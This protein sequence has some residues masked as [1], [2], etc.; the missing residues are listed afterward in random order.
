MPR[1]KLRNFDNSLEF[2]GSNNGLTI[3]GY[4]VPDSFSFAFWIKFD[5][6]DNSD[7]ILDNQDG[8]PSGGFDLDFATA[9][10]KLS[11]FVRN[12]GSTTA[13]AIS[14]TIRK[15]VWYHIVGVRSTTFTQLYVNAVAEGTADTSSIMSATSQTLTI[16]KRCTGASNFFDG[17]MNQFLFFERVLTEDEINALYFDGII[18]ATPAIRYDFGDNIS[19][20]SGNGND[21]VAVGTLDY[22]LD[23]PNKTR[24]A[25][26][27]S[28]V[29]QVGGVDFKMRGWN[30][31]SNY[32]DGSSTN[33]WYQETGQLSYDATDISSAGMNVVKIYGTEANGSSHIAAINAMLAVDANLKF[34]VLDFVTYETDYSVA[35]GGA[36]RTAKI[37]DFVA[38]VNIFKDSD[39]VIGYGFGNENNVNLGSTTESDWY[40]LLDAACAAGKAVDSTRFY[41]TADADLGTYPGDHNVPNLDVLGLNI[42]RGATLT[43]LIPDIQRATR[44][45]VIIT[46]FG[47]SRTT[48]DAPDLATQSSEN[49]A[50]LQEI[51]SAYPT[52]SGWC[53]FKFTDTV[54]PGT[55]YGATAPLADNATEARTKYDT[56]TDFSTYLNANPYG[57]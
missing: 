45:P 5:T 35:T 15:G 13:Q 18:P 2:N 39:A 3:D 8:G 21:G 27:Y 16:G 52:I 41:F 51:E 50:L 14:S 36:N 43:D 31:S 26:G 29:V 34:I 24:L 9:T 28:R 6:V 23:V 37:A 33:P 10:N 19:D 38:M 32:L 20:S 12:G 30:Y 40:S 46:E 49:L 56:Y 11:L 44:K 47:R 57:G 53:H 25:N 1:I 22:S 17:L 42:Y 7:R 55:V 54:A 48:N 4:S